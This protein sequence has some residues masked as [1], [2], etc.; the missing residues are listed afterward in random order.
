MANRCDTSSGINLKPHENTCHS[1]ISSS[2]SP[3]KA[4]F[5][6][7]FLSY[8]QCY[9]FALTYYVESTET[10]TIRCKY[11]NFPVK[12]HPPKSHNKHKLKAY[13]THYANYVLY[14]KH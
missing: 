10:C 5:L 4:F 11:F 12:N 8:Q 14:E 2:K 3:S 6:F 13:K 1:G 7:Q 9:N